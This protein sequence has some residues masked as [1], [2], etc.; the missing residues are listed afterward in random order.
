MTIGIFLDVILKNPGEIE[1]V[2]YS[3]EQSFLK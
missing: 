1:N 2:Y 3:E